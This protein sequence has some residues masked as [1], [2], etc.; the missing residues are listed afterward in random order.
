MRSFH[1][2]LTA[3]LIV[4]AAAQAVVVGAAQAADDPLAPLGLGARPVLPTPTPV[5][6]TL[7][8]VEITDRHRGF[9]S[10]SP[11]VVAWMKDEGGY[12]RRVLDAIG[13]LAELRQRVAAFTA[14]FGLVKD[15]ASEGGRGFYLERRPGSDNFDLMVRDG[16]G[17]RALVDMTALRAA[18]GDR[19][20]AINYF[21]ASP[22]GNRVAVGI[23]EGGSEAASLSVYDTASGRRI[24]GPIDRAQFGPTSWS[25]DS[26][27][28]YFIRLKALVPSDAPTEKYR[29]PMLQSWSQGTAPVALYGSKADRGPKFGPDETPVLLASPDPAAKVALLLS[30]NG[31]QNEIKAW[32]APVSAIGRA[33]AHWTKLLDR[34]DGVTISDVRGSTL[35]LLSHKGAP[36][37]QV[38]QVEAGAPLSSA[39]VLVRARP[40]R[41]IESLHAA[42]DALYVTTLDGVYSHLLRIPTGSTTIE[43]IAL[44]MRGHIAEFFVD[45]RQPGATFSLENMITPTTTYRFDPAAKSFTDLHLGTAGAFDPAAFTVSDLKARAHDGAEVPFSVVQPRDASGPRTM[46]IEAYGSYGISELAD[47]SGRRAVAMKEGISY[48]VCHVRGGGELGEAWRL[49]GKDSHKPNTWRDLIACADDAVARGLTTPD[50]LFIIGGSAGGITMGRAMEERPK[51]FAGVLDMVPAANT[52]RSEFSPNGPDNIPEFG[53]ITSKQ[54]FANLYEMDSVVHVRKGTAYPA[55]LISTGLNDPRVAPWIPA[56]FAASLIEAGGPNPVLLRVDTQ[57]G[58]GMGSTRAQGDL[59]AADSIAF[60]F[61]RA[62]RPGWRPQAR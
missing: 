36:T 12:T 49:G 46:I 51:L 17:A 56:K 33:D 57:A 16:A 2:G 60:V 38:L 53:T 40:D 14:S 43:E 25:A 59:L 45:P 39:T 55:I 15:Y 20:M 62:G 48:G 58:H 61:W 10:L 29:D 13:P 22:D 3:M 50:R 41:V 18:A 35:F 26:A 44:P 37:F 23:S 11:P 5:T 6:E 34:A 1:S 54:G 7:W 47:F 24:G 31:V 4:A 27:M 52:L 28:L 19:P 21:L 30:Q 8:G 9:E 32:T 42:S